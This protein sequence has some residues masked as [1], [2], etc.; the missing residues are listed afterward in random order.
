VIKQNKRLMNLSPYKVSDRFKNKNI[1]K[2]DW[3]ECNLP[4]SGE[5]KSLFQKE[6]DKIN[7]TEYPD[8]NN[9]MLIELLANYCNLK[10][11]NIE[12]FNGS[13]SALQNIFSC[14]VDDDVTVLVYDPN[15][16]QI[17]S[18]IQLQTSKII[19][20]SIQ[21]VFTQPWYDFSLIENADVI[22]ISNPN[23]P[24]GYLLSPSVIATLVD[25]N[26]DK[27]FIIDEAYYEFCKQS[28]AHL[29]ATYDNIVV[30]RTFSK[31][32]SLASA[33]LGYICT[34]EKNIETINKIR[35]KKEVNSYA[36]HFG[37]VILKNVDLFD[38]RVSVVNRN[39]SFFINEIKKLQIEFCDSFSN[40]VL[41]R[42]NNHKK[43][44]KELSDN[45]ILVRDR[46]NIPGLENCLRITIDTLQNMEHV[47]EILSKND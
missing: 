7:L 27:L 5:I 11:K 46:S 29:A 34:G 26:P 4:L 28:C 12:I 24:T 44:L 39:K 38:K 8:I 2:L 35:N 47:L 14:F 16:T 18:Y 36:Q 10:S 33:R 20:S 13:D 40:F 22:Y 15:Y 41:I 6:F 43:V 25:E 32:F 17:D 45:N 30:T 21:N 23:N 19:R 37:A 31:A 3:N 42:L 1:K 9:M